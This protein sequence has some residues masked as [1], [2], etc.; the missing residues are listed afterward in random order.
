MSAGIAHRKSFAGAAGSKQ[1]PCGCPI[2]NCIANNRVLSRD[3]TACQSR[4]HHNHPT[5]QAFANII[6]GITR[7]LELETTGCKSPKRLTSTAGQF[8]RQMVVLE[9][10]I[11]PKF[12]HNMT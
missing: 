4:P 12:F 7:H 1:I 8:D 9:T 2:E 6:I 11:H 3:Q 10:V 5:R